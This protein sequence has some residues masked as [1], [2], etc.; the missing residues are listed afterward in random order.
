MVQKNKNYFDLIKLQALAIKLS[1][2]LKS[3]SL[4]LL[5]GELGAGKTTFARFLINNLYELN[6]LKAPNSIKSPSFPILLTYDLDS[7]EIFHYDLY[8]IKNI[9]ELNELNIDENINQSITIIEW[10]ELILERNINYKYHLV[11]LKIQNEF[12][13]LVDLNYKNYND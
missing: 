10:P 4:I 3:G 2:E 12:I 11:E 13:R 6:N 9:S 7:I 8:R 5:K 1:L